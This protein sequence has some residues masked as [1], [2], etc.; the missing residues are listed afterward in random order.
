MLA[1]MAAQ[2]GERSLRDIAAN[3]NVDTTT[4]HHASLHVRTSSLYSQY[5]T[6]CCA[7]MPT[8]SRYAQPCPKHASAIQPYGNEHA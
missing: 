7:R 3:S 2:M 4:K 6:Q 5:C 8:R 1:H